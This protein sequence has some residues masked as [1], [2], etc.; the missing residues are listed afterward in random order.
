MA[1]ADDL[2]L[3]SAAS[4]LAAGVSDHGLLAVLPMQPGTIVSAVRRAPE[5]GFCGVA[6]DTLLLTCSRCKS[7]CYCSAAHQKQHWY[8]FFKYGIFKRA[9]NIGLLSE[10]KPSIFVLCRS[11]HKPHCSEQ[12][13]VLSNLGVSSSSGLIGDTMATKQPQ[14]ALE[15]SHTPAVLVLACLFCGES[16]KKL[17]LCGKCKAARYCGPYHQKLH[18]CGFYAF[19]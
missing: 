10:K 14:L 2:T 4:A 3:R 13:A 5:C 19:F 16:N 8:Y 6:G 12:A 18:W 7:M 11:T 9:I 17:L 15:G 1:A